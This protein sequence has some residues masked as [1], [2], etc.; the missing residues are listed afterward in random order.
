M[1]ILKLLSVERGIDS[2]RMMLR[3]EQDKGHKDRYCWR[4]FNTDQ[5]SV[6]GRR[7]HMVMVPA[8]PRRSQGSPSTRA[9]NWTRFRVTRL[10][11]LSVLA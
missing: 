4:R 5:W 1:H 2:E 9:S 10:V 3:V 7:Q 8:S 11:P 6:F